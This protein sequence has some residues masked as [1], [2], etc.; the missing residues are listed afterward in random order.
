MPDSINKLPKKIFGVRSS[1]RINHPQ[2]TAKTDSRLKIIAAVVG[3]AIRCPTTCS[4]YAIP[5]EIIPPYR[6]G[7]AAER[8]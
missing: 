2:N 7:S 6:I 3:L 5:I 8:T 1:F 4:V